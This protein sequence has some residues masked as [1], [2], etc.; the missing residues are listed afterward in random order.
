MA[1]AYFAAGCFWGVEDAV[2][3]L[4]GVRDAVSGYQ[5]GHS[6]DPT[7]EAV[8]AGNTGHAETVRITFE[9]SQITY[10]Q[11]LKWYFD[12]FGPSPSDTDP[13]GQYRGAIFASD[14]EQLAEANAYAGER[15]AGREMGTQI[16]LG[17]PFYEA[18]EYHQD[19]VARQRAGR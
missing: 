6:V 17:G 4:P 12:R 8:C 1:E 18:E 19:Y 15:Y 10:R 2:A 3:K 7:Y 9:P 16:R 14:E 5:G 11:L 13:E